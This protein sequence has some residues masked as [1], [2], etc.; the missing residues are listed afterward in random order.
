MDVE[1]LRTDDIPQEVFD[2]TWFELWKK[3]LTTHSELGW[4]LIWEFGKLNDV[5]RVLSP[6]KIVHHAD[7]WGG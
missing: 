3:T 5:P 4:P 1:L 7:K 2:P 6:Q